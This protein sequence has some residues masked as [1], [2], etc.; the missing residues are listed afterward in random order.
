LLPSSMGLSVLVP[1]G[2]DMFKVIVAWGDYLYE[3]ATNEPGDAGPTVETPAELHDQPPAYGQDQGTVGPLSQKG[4]RRDPREEIVPVPLPPT[5]GKPTQFMV[6][7]SDRLTLS[8][9]VRPVPTA[10]HAAGRLP[11]GTRSVSVFLVNNRPPNNERHY[12]AFAFQTSLTLFCPEPF[13]P[14]PDLRGSLSGAL[15][16]DWDEQVATFN[17]ATCLNTPSVTA[18][19][20]PPSAIRA[21][22]AMS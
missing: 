1:P 2:V 14:R 21:A 10:G 4:Y 9:I 18:F 20:P 12:R 5:G 15:A 16:H 7:D 13:V 3:G 19:Q 11:V 6:P 22:S 17:S 8:V